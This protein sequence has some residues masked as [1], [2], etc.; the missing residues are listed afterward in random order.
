MHNML[1]KMSNMEDSF[2]Y[3]RHSSVPGV[4]WWAITA[5]RYQTDG[6]NQRDRPSEPA[7]QIKDSKLPFGPVVFLENSDYLLENSDHS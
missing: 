7:R 1:M 3:I 5:V 6:V 2:V 4:Q